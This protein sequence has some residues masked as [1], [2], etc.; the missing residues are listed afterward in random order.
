L[1]DKKGDKAGLPLK[2]EDISGGPDKKEDNREPKEF[3]TKESS[4]LDSLPERPLFSDLLFDVPFSG[5][6]IKIPFDGPFLEIPFSGK[7]NSL[8]K[9]G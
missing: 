6:F 3:G 4:P 5:F 1:P 9:P 2:K 8:S 7:F